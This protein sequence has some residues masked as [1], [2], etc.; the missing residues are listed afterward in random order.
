MNTLRRMAGV[1]VVPRN[2]RPFDGAW[3]L[4]ELGRAIEGARPTPLPPESWSIRGLGR[5]LGYPRP[6]RIGSTGVWSMRELCF[7]KA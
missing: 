5:V 3:S 1:D 4:R 2:A 6:F 7:A